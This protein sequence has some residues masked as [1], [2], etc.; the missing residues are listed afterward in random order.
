[1]KC[2]TFTQV[3]MTNL[4]NLDTA[5]H[6]MVISLMIVMKQLALDVN[7]ILIVIHHLN[8]QGNASPTDN[9]AIIL[10]KKVTP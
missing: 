1:M 4:I 9:L 7:L 2:T 10:L 3:V 6:V 8:A 5:M